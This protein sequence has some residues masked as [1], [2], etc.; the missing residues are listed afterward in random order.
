[1]R[2]FGDKALKINRYELHATQAG[3]YL[4]LHPEGEL[5]KFDDV[6]DLKQADGLPILKVKSYTTEAEDDKVDGRRCRFDMLSKLI[7]SD[8]QQYRGLKPRMMHITTK[9]WHSLVWAVAIVS[10]E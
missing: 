7:D 1:M 2:F 5:V 6:A 9:T 3:S 8:A 4:R 10:W